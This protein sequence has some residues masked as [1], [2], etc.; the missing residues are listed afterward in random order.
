M[1][2]WGLYDIPINITS[3]LLAIAIPFCVCGIIAVIGGIF[4]IQR[5]CWGMALAGSIAAF[6]P[7][8]IFGLG[9]VVFIAI[10]RDEFGTALKKAGA[11]GKPVGVPDKS[12]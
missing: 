10:S 1:G 12:V 7:A 5:K 2:N 3:I 6:F 8:W 4:A 11:D 9:S